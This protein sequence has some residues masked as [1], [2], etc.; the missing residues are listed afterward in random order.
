MEIVQFY[1]LSIQ[2]RFTR[3][4]YYVPTNL[5]FDHHNRI[6][7]EADFITYRG[8]IELPLLIV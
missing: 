1:K 6:F 3:G 4:R 7:F 8:R 5:T 2:Y